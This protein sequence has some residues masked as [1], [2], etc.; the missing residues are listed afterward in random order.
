MW[1]APS[2]IVLRIL[3][4][5]AVAATCFVLARR[6]H[7]SE[8]GWAV[9]GVAACLLFGGVGLAVPI[10]LASRD[11]VDLRRHYLELRAQER[12]LQV[13]GGPDLGATISVE[14][15]ILMILANNPGGLHL[16]AIAQGVG[17]SWRAISEPMNRLVRQG[18]VCMRDDL[19]FLEGGDA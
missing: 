19:Y 5:A 16:N 3:L 11:K 1:F 8:M 9:L 14:E 10:W 6:R 12:L 18:R 4:S 2:S 17:E 13:L 15:R 7:R